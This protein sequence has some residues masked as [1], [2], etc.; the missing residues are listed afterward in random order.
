M[1][2]SVSINDKIYMVKL[3]LTLRWDLLSSKPNRAGSSMHL[4]FDIAIPKKR[5][6]KN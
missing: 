1:Q 5:V 2:R 4:M 3:V 6:G